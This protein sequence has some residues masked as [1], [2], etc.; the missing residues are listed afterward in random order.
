MALR[1]TDE[2]VEFDDVEVEHKTD[3][4][5]L[6][7]INDAKHWI[8]FSHIDEEASELTDKSSKGD[9]GLLVIGE[10]LAMEKSLI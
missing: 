1:D 4:A 8:P 2:R 3:A 6:C 9:V 10:W 5:L 7:V